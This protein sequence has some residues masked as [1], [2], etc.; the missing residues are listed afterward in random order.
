MSCEGEG[1]GE[2]GVAQKT[3]AEEVKE[4]IV[5]GNKDQRRGL[6]RKQRQEGNVRNENQQQEVAN[7]QHTRLQT[8]AR[9]EGGNA[10]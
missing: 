4:N 10:S 6:L 8:H 1:G 9:P 2:D 3:Q 7:P 5:E